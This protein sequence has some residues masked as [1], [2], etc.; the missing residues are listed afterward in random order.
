MV[1]ER[2]LQ[3][4]KF[5]ARGEII[6]I[7]RTIEEKE[8]Y[9]IF[10]IPNNT[11]VLVV[12][13]TKDTTLEMVSFLLQI[14]VNHLTLVPYEEGKDF[15]D[16]KVAITPGEKSRVPGYIKKIIDVDNRCIDISTF[17]KII[18]KLGLDNKRINERL[19]KYSDNIISLDIGIKNK[20]NELLIRNEQFDTVINLSKDGILLLNSKDEILICNQQF[21]TIF[22]IKEEITNK[23]I[24]YFLDHKIAKVL[25]KENLTDELMEF[26]RKYIN[27]NKKCIHYLGQKIVNDS[28]RKDLFYRL[29]ILPINIPPLRDRKENILLLIRHFIDNNKFK[30][31]PEVEEQL[32]NYTWPVT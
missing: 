28:F 14:G 25:Q 2:T 15:S 21:K 16:I 3:A 19:I 1:K 18:T 7:Q 29:N 23:N 24:N 30:L 5:L 13:D 8:A 6:V 17:I 20:Y 4:K 22:S 32:L 26:K 12:N 27:I 31:S 9:K 10:F 11:R